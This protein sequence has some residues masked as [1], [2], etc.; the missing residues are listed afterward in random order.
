MKTI[1]KNCKR[2]NVEFEADLREHNRGNAHFCSR[3][4]SS[5]Y[6]AQKR[7]DNNPDWYN[8]TCD[9]CNKKIHK[10]PSK[11]K[12][13]KSGYHFCSRECKEY[14]QSFKSEGFEPLQP[15]HYKSGHHAV[16][17]NYIN[18]SECN[19]CGYNK[20]PEII[21]VH[22]KDRNRS[23]NSVDNLEALCPNCHWTEHFL[24]G[25][26]WFKSKR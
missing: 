12:L 24:A 21:H 23:N 14:A 26:G 25:D 18:T 17:R 11:I 3:S 15:D 10:S 1:T 6:N 19:R 16:Y 22:H 7:K 8:K 4:C 2:C 20:H 13:S 9:V 5:K